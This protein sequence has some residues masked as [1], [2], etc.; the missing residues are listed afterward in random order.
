MSHWINDP[1][2]RRGYSG[3]QNHTTDADASWSHEQG[4][5]ARVAEEEARFR[6]SWVPQSNSAAS[7]NY[8]WRA[9]EA[10][11]PPQA[12]GG[13]LFDALGTLLM[14][15]VAPL[16]I[17]GPSLA[18]S[19]EVHKLLTMLRSSKYTGRRRRLCSVLRWALVGF[20]P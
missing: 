4:R 12:G 1:N 10:P 20:T 6:A 17:L 18:A 5:L 3:Q 13:D 14:I 2:W 11:L 9:N 15:L 16:P 8:D 7:T 19:Y